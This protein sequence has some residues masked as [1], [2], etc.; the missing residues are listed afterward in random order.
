M[1]GFVRVAALVDVA[2]GATLRIEV[3]G[4]P[5]CLVNTEGQVYALRDNCSHKDFPLSEGE[6]LGHRLTCAWHGAAFD[7]TTGNALSL[8]AVKPVRTFDVEVEDGQ[9]WVRLS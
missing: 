5:I 7:V 1:E 2:P 9:V 4:I 3:D 8:P 6:V